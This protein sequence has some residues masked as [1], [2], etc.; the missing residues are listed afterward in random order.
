[1]TGEVKKFDNDRLDF[2]DTHTVVVKNQLYAFKYRF[3]V[4]IYKIVDFNSTDHLITTLPA[5]PRNENLY[6]FAVSYWAAAGSIVLTGGRDS[7]YNL[8]AQTLL[9]AVQTGLWEQRSFPELNVARF[10]HASMTQGKQC[11]VAGGMADGYGYKKLS[12]MEMLRMGAQAW[13]LID[14]PDFTPRNHVVFS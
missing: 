4:S 3:P 7:N 8:T 6:Y 11:Y 9:L 5:L 10:M 14:I 2:T 13:E 1:M 12:S